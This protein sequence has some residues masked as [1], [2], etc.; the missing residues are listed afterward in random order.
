MRQHVILLLAFAAF[1]TTQLTGCP[2]AIFAGGT[3]GAASIASDQRT[4]GTVIEDQA[5]EFRIANSIQANPELG[6][7]SHVSVTSYNNYVLLTGET[8]SEDLRNL[9]YEIALQDPKVKKVYNEL[10]LAEPLP[11]NAR[12]YDSWL[13]TKVK[14]KLLTV[15]EINS[16]QVK[17][18]TS[19]QTVYLLGIVPD[20]TGNL[21][22]EVA[23]QV[24]GVQKVVKAFEYSEANQ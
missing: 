21:A 11:L 6:K 5:I 15:K 18:V 12:N 19:N 2:A 17:V 7:N 8:P 20:T 9:A 23:A 3:A 13:T 22:A 16:F 14:T 10:Q 4:T 1:S 24:D